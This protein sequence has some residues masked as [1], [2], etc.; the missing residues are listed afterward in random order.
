MKAS[1]ANRIA[2]KI[3]DLTVVWLCAWALPLPYPIG[4]LLGFFYSLSADC[5]KI[6]SKQ[7]Q[8][9]GKKIVGIQTVSHRGT[10]GVRNP[11]NLK[12]SIYRNAPVGVATF[13]GLIPFWGWLIM[14]LIGVPLMVM[15]IYLMLSVEGGR[16]LGDVMADTEVMPLRRGLFR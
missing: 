11:C 1:V 15:E 8:S 2:A 3:I 10:D 14:I 7:S 13:F 9:I 6:G 16:R 4:P 5:L 12:E